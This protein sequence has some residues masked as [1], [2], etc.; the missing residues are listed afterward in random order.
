MEE[1]LVPVPGEVAYDLSPSSGGRDNPD[2]G[3]GGVCGETSRVAESSLYREGIKGTLKVEVRFDEAFPC[4]VARGF[5]APLELDEGD[6]FFD[7]EFPPRSAARISSCELDIFSPFSDEKYGQFPKRTIALF[8]EKIEFAE[9]ES[10][11]PSP[12]NPLLVERRT[13]HIIGLPCGF[14]T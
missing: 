9:G 10:A 2:E 6:S 4:E 5:S 1:E 13:N 3:G 7:V 12:R 14:T 8:S 11:S